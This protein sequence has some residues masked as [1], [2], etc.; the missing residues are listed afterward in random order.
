MPPSTATPDHRQTVL[1]LV[2]ALAAI[3][4]LLAAVL[5]RA[6]ASRAPIESGTLLQAPRALPDFALLDE[7]AQPFTNRQLE[8]RWTLIF[9][10]FTYCP[11]VCPTTLGLLKNVEA[12]LGDKAQK[13]QIVLFSVDP[14]RDTPETLNRYVHHFSPRFKGATTAE[15][16]LKTLAQ[17]LGVAYVKVPGESPVDGADNYTMDHSAALVLINPRG[18]LAGYFTPP[19]RVDSL[20]RDLARILEQPS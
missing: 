7:N 1:I 10:G 13:L 5:L 17:A 12:Q 11:D 4:G 15:P 3:A 14:E 18:E 8:G 2:A 16:A 19:L 9:P 6:P 20:V